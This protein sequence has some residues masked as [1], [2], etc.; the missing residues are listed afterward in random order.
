MRIIFTTTDT[1]RLTVTFRTVRRGLDRLRERGAQF[2]SDQTGSASVEYA[3]LLCLLVAASVGA[4]TALGAQVRRNLV[5]M[6]STL[7]RPTG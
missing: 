7:S 5:A 4:W 2:L 6:T 1:K 3:L